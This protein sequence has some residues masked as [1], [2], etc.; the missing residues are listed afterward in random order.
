MK[1][2]ILQDSGENMPVM[3]GNEPASS[4]SRGLSGYHRIFHRG[5]TVCTGI[6]KARYF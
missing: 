2:W 4:R 1:T 3:P 5:R 6:E